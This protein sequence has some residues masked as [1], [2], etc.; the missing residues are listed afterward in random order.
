MKT[1]E[2]EG[3]SYFWSIKNSTEILL[4]LKAKGFHASYISTNDFLGFILY[5]L[6]HD[7]ITNQLVD[8]IEHTYRP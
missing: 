1:Y 7:L 4:K 5:T 3:I 2:R 6:P 8:L